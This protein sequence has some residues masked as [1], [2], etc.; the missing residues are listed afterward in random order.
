MTADEARAAA[1]IGV[2]KR[3]EEHWEE[4]LENIAEAASRG[5]F[6][7]EVDA[8]NEEEWKKLTLMG[9]EV[10]KGR[11]Y[12][13]VYWLEDDSVDGVNARLGIKKF[14]KGDNDGGEKIPIKV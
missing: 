3:I 10:K 14:G 6:G 8:L 7:T 11:G 1:E 5:Y 4:V 12:W 2:W 9:Y 13:E